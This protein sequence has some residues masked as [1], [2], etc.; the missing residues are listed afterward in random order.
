MPCRYLWI[1][2]VYNVTYTLALYALLLFYLGTHDLLAPFKPMLKFLVVKSIVFLTFWQVRKGETPF[3]SEK[4]TF[5][6]DRLLR[7]QYWDLSG[8]CLACACPWAMAWLELVLAIAAWAARGVYGACPWCSFCHSSWQA[9]EE[10]P[11]SSVQTAS[12]SCQHLAQVMAVC[13]HKLFDSKFV[14]PRWRPTAAASPAAA[15]SRAEPVHR[16]PEQRRSARQ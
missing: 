5:R 4:G 10:L 8:H 1:T 3:P 6:C 11:G 7:K 9:A 12:L 14:C 13:Q 16:H 2:L 15:C